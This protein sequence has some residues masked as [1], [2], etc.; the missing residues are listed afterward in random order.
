M[1]SEKLKVSPDFSQIS[2]VLQTR[3]LSGSKCLAVWDFLQSLLRVL[4]MSCNPKTSK[5]LGLA[6][7]NTGLTL[8][9]LPFAIP[10]Y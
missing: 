9:H 10:M 2:W 1:V 3:F 8:S 4:I 7:K 6:E 5:S